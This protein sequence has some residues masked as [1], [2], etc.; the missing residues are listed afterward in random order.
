MKRIIGILAAVGLWISAPAGAAAQDAPLF[1][2]ANIYFGASSGSG[3]GFDADQNIQ[4]NPFF[5]GQTET[6]KE[7][8]GAKA[9]VG[10]D[11]NK[12][13][14]AEIAYMY[15][16]EL[17]STSTLISGSSGQTARTKM[18]ENLATFSLILGADYNR[19]FNPFVKG[20]GVIAHQKFEAVLT[21]DII[22]GALLTGSTVDTG[23]LMGFGNTL[24]LGDGL[25]MRLEWELY[26][27]EFG[28]FGDADVM[29]NFISAG[30]VW[31]PGAADG[32]AQGAPMFPNSNFYVGAS[33]GFGFG[34]DSH[35]NLQV[36]GFSSQ[37]ET[38]KEGFGAKAFVGVDISRHLAA[39]IAYMYTPELTSTSTS[40]NGPFGQI[41]RTRV[42]EN[43]AA[44]SLIYGA[45]YNRFFNPFV[46][47]G[48]VI[49]HQQFQTVTT[50]NTLGQLETG[51]TA[52]TGYLLGLGNTLHLRDGLDMRLE[53]EIYNTDFGSASS[54]AIM[55]NFISA[56]LVWTPGGGDGA[57][58]VSPKLPGGVFYLGAS[59]GFGFG[60]DADSHVQ[61][62]SSSAFQ[63][64]A[65]KEGAGAKAFAGVNLNRHLAA[66]IAYMAT[67]ELTSTQVST[68]VPAISQN[69]TRTRVQENLATFSLILGANY[70]W[71]FNPFVKGG[72]LIAH[73]ESKSVTT[74][75][76]GQLQT[77]STVDTGYLMGLG[78]SV[79]LHD[80]LDMRMEWEIYETGLGV[81]NNFVSAGLVWT[82]GAENEAGGDLSLPRESIFYVGASSGYGFNFNADQTIQAP[83]GFSQF[84]FS[85]EGAGGKV[86]AGVNL[87]RHLA[88]EIAYMFKPDFMG[89]QTFLSG[90]SGLFGKI[91]GQEHIAAVS[92]ILGTD[93][94][95]YL[96]PFVKGGGVITQLDFETV[97]TGSVGELASGAFADSGYLLG[98]GNTI[99]LGDDLDMRVEWE[100]YDTAATGDM[101]NFISAGLVL[102]L[103]GGG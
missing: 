95:R 86:F 1:P 73:Q 30:L 67:P 102:K 90:N 31:T 55:N 61:V 69:M 96:N 62:T 12:H 3:F 75:S 26:N 32:A 24:H 100:V 98:L 27:T 7:G 40:V 36:T 43:L 9:F 47:G 93:Y 66:E 35:N 39:E 33:S 37:T 2:D 25:D 6:T 13:L 11:I 28:A 87:N 42:Q 94:N 45:D 18:Q 22:G 20:G 46:K 92:L 8:F 17:T 91:K 85:K 71:F 56:G 77:S 41:S 14:A 103:G 44:F 23:Y 57:V 88:G 53:W 51:S 78:N 15:T 64:E 83:T 89:S 63:S 29:N 59:S 79:H 19:F 76:F 72:G 81:M 74:G 21:G 101:N 99:H 58:E 68:S 49:S 80:G 84:E 97:T 54:D 34:F 10:V 50:S 16:P 65:T 70:D 60:F 82:P 4:G 48:G 52:Y 5:S 38:T